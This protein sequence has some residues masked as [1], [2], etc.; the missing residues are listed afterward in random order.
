MEGAR[1]FLVEVKKLPAGDCGERGGSNAWGGKLCAF[2]EQAH[3]QHNVADEDKP[4]CEWIEGS[5]DADLSQQTEDGQGDSDPE[6]NC[7]GWG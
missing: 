2:D 3:S 5:D 1:G 7:S 6:N 4:K